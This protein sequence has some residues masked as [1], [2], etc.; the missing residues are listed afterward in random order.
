MSLKQAF[1]DHARSLAISST[2]ALHGHVMGATGA[3]EAVIAVLA[4]CSGRLPPTAH[5]ARSDPTFDLDFVADGPRVAS[6]LA[7]VMS[8]SFAFGGTNAVLIARRSAGA[9]N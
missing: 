6:E 1:G 4:L 5:L 9:R 3:I 7:A 2:K 8:N